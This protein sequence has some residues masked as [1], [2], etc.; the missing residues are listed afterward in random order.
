M[1]G[2][3][4]TD[5]FDAQGAERVDE[6]DAGIELGIASQA[7]FD[8]RHSDQHQANLI[9]IKQIAELFQARNLEPIG[10]VDQD[11]PGGRQ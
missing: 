11:K 7:L 3:Q 9:A 4:P 2:E 1:L 6:A 10:F 8:A 5:F